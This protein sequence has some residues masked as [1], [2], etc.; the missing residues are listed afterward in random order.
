MGWKIRKR[1]HATGVYDQGATRAVRDYS[2]SIHDWFVNTSIGRRLQSAMQ[3]AGTVDQV[4]VAAALPPVADAA[5]S[6][7]ASSA[8]LDTQRHLARPVVSATAGKDAQVA[9]DNISDDEVEKWTK[10]LDDWMTESIAALPIVGS[11]SGKTGTAEESA[12]AAASSAPAVAASQPASSSS[13]R[14]TTSPDQPAL[15]P[16]SVRQLN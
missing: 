8:P 13:S 11:G 1:M 10:D 3:A 12:V 2:N 7:A 9:N 14:D 15:E 5:S 6:V 16:S 4:D